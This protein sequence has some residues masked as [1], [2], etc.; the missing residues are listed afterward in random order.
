VG[1]VIVAIAIGKE[2]TVEHSLVSMW[3]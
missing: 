3:V 1:S 2:G